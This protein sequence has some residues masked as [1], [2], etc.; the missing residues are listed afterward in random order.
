M[1]ILSQTPFFLTVNFEYIYISVSS[2]GGPHY[3]EKLL[4]VDLVLSDIICY[5]QMNIQ[6]HITFY[7]SNIE[8]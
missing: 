6:K 1:I 7:D 4:E 2:K 8:V 3:F 5:K